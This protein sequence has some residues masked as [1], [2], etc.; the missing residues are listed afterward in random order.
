[1]EIKFSEIKKSCIKAVYIIFIIN[2]K[3][4]CLTRM[5]CSIEK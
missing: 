4:N 2:A 3:E 5:T 1:M